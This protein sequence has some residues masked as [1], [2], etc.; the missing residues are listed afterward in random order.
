MSS[1][2]RGQTNGWMDGWGEWKRPRDK[3]KR[4]R[5]RERETHTQM[6]AGSGRRKHREIV[7]VFWCLTLPEGRPQFSS[8]VSTRFLSAENILK[9]LC[10]THT[11]TLQWVITENTT[12]RFHSDTL[13]VKC[14]KCMQEPNLKSAYSWPKCCT[15]SGKHTKPHETVE[16]KR[17]TVSKGDEIWYKC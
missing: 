2:E 10:E 12:Q 8:A 11:N 13:R 4:G 5:Q 16:K 9:I 1:I 15:T 6:A 17:Y 3:D 7:S 14:V